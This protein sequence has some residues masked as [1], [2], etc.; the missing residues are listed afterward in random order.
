M[1]SSLNASHRMKRIFCLILFISSLNCFSQKIS[2]IKVTDLEKRISN[3]SDT[4]YI[5]NFWATWCAP[6]VKELPD[7]DSITKVYGSEKVKILLI[8]L[9][10]KEDMNTKI[11]PFYNRKR[12]RSEVYLLDEANGNYFIPRV[13]EQWTG[14]IPATLILNNQKKYRAFYEK[15]LSYEFLKGEIEGIK[16]K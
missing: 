6:C 5:V 12:L 1:D 10:F 14:A 3:D 7:F 13:S 4:T 2:T 11:I 16:N 9:D 8:S 15:K